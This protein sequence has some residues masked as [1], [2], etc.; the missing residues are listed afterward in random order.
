[1][2]KVSTATAFLVFFGALFYQSCTNQSPDSTKA[3]AADRE[4][5]TLQIKQLED[6]LRSKADMPIDRKLA[7]ELILKSIAYAEAFPE[8][9]LSPAHLFRAGNV[10]IGIGSFEE[11][12]S[13][14]EIIHQKYGGYERA[15]D[16]LFLEGFTY[17]NHLKNKEKA[18]ICYNDFLKRFP[19]DQ[20]ADQVRVVLEN[21]DKTPEELV[22]SFQ[23]K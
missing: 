23:Q 19:D 7:K 18:K 17:E 16:A 1:M 13:Y 9:E 12:A 14:F 8:D 2:G 20:L 3:P 10:A 22:K 4:L 6:T 21:I 11:A 15:P 5:L